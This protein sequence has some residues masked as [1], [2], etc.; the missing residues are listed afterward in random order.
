MLKCVRTVTMATSVQRDVN[1]IMM[2]N[3]IT[4][5]D[6][7]SVVQVSGVHGKY[8]LKLYFRQTANN[9]FC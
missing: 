3:V 7:V 8:P 5:A 9:R 4:L 1:V 6:I 2:L